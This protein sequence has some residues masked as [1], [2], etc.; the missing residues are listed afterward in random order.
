VGHL[1]TNSGKN[2]MLV[3]ISLPGG[4]EVIA[5]LLA[6][7]DVVM[8]NFAL[9]A[10]ERLGIGEARVRG[11]NPGVIY[12]S[13]S[14][15]TSRGPLGATRGWEP[16]GQSPTGIMLRNGDGIPR[17]SRLMICDYGTGHL[18]AFAVLLGLLHR[19]NTGVG[20]HVEASLMQTGTY[21]QIPFAIDFNGIRRDE[22]RG[23]SVQEWSPMDGLYETSDG[24]ISV[25]GDE[26]ALR[27]LGKITGL[28]E[29]GDSR[30]SSFSA[31]LR[32]RFRSEPTEVWVD[33]LTR[34]RI[35]AH[36]VLSV[37]EAMESA[38]ARERGLSVVREHY[39]IGLVRSIGPGTRLSRTPT[40]LTKPASLPGADSR[41]VLESL[42]WGERW[43]ELVATGSAS[44]HLIDAAFVAL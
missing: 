9:G 7:S 42:G 26:G 6:G 5:D 12:A 33:R 40:R 15:S 39:G 35:A 24:W 22:P 32:E 4:K 16:M 2:N 37:E 29:L 38:V 19:S 31:S 11:I 13:V 23:P 8:E 43:D 44:D 18:A 34:A 3:D 21:L 27:T 36:S 20:Q 10:A 28:A 30:S 14:A 17:F 25:H 41:R 1:L